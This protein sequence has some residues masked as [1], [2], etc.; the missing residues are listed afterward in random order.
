VA[1]R[2][3]MPHQTGPGR[4]QWHLRTEGGRDS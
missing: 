2:R 3:S 4:D 1:G